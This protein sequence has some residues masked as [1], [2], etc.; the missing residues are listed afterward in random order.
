MIYMHMALI[1]KR[2]ATEMPETRK[3]EPGEYPEE[4]EIYID[5]ITGD[6]VPVD[7]TQRIP[8]P[9]ALAKHVDVLTKEVL[10]T[11]IATKEMAENIGYME[12]RLD[13]VNTVLAKTKNTWLNNFDA[14]D[15]KFESVN[16][17]IVF[18]TE[19][20]E[21]T[22]EKLA[23]ALEMMVGVTEA[24]GRFMDRLDILESGLQ[25]VEKRLPKETN[26]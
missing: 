14:S 7:K 2:K 20:Q 18:V 1:D 11:S 13:R 16:A 19:A 26:D 10:S 6:I 5:P 8:D 12:A 17:A 21:K 24:M 22:N 15:R 9:A 25:Y 4:L 3:Y 23:K